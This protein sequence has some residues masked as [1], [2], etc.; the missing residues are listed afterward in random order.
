[1]YFF[2]FLIYNMYKYICNEIYMEVSCFVTK[3]WNMFNKDL[4]T[5]FLFL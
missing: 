2:E 5:P 1:M 4:E 3:M